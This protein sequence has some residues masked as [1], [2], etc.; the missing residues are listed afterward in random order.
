[1]LEDTYYSN[2]KDNFK[3]NVFSAAEWSA[4]TIV[5][6]I[7]IKE[8][9]S[10]FQLE[11]KKIKRMKI[12]GLA[13]NLRRDWIEESAYNRLEELGE[14]MRQL[15]SDYEN[16]EPSLE[17][18]RYA[19]IDEPFLIEFEDGDVFEID[20]PQEPE[21]RFS[22]NSIPWWIEAGTNKPNVEA[23][24]LFSPCLGKKVTSIEIKTY[25]TDQDPMYRGFFDEQHSSRELTSGI[26]IWLEGGIGLLFEGWI[27]FCHVSLIDESANNIPISFENL[28]PALFNSEDLHIDPISKYEAESS[29]FYFGKIGADHTGEPYMTLV[30]GSKETTLNISVADFLLFEWSISLYRNEIF[31][32]YGEYEFSSSEWGEILSVAEKLLSFPTFDMLFEYMKDTNITGYSIIG[33][34]KYN[35][36]L[37]SI[38]C[39]GARFW[40][41]HRRYEMQ[42][43]DMRNW[44]NHVLEKDEKMTI[45]GF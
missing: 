38:N 34:E 31:D 26:I 4:P 20:T 32:E 28:K 1:M 6:P 17:L 5:S 10:A 21:Y 45:Y 35:V 40:K 8:R 7:E 12:I 11:G 44:T 19:E 30:P 22:L 36:M 27:D 13:Y 3:D 39:C 42:L 18:Y 15:Q 41:Q 37:N 14:E 9:I 43:Q 23:D 25:T 33:G 16:I 29:T 24:I 2:G